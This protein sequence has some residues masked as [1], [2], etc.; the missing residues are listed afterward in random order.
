MQEQERAKNTLQRGIKMKGKDLD[1]FIALYEQLTRE[2]GYDHA[3][4]LC[5]KF[6]TDG[7]PNELYQD[8]LQL[9][10]PCNYNEWREAALE[11]QVECHEPVLWFVTI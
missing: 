9:D 6:F 8:I 5:L 1:G 4:H 11:R 10:Q 2:A 3:N 7:L